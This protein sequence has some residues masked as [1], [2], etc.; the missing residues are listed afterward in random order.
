M[1]KN[2]NSG[3]QDSSEK[4]LSL[5]LPS[6][7]SV[8]D[9]HVEWCASLMRSVFQRSI[10]TQSTSHAKKVQRKPWDPIKLLYTKKI[11]GA[12]H[13]DMKL[14]ITMNYHLEWKML[15]YLEF[16]LHTVLQLYIYTRA[17]IHIYYI[18]IYYNMYYT[19]HVVF[20]EI[21]SEVAWHESILHPNAHK[22][23]MALQPHRPTITA[24]GITPASWATP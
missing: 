9:F 17:E 12:W 2:N 19:V 11:L 21:W 1:A 6:N 4:L 7:S 3:T 16:L 5:S 23:C 22:R 8:H 18:I 24:R 15:T 14:L 13:Y 20:L 10:P